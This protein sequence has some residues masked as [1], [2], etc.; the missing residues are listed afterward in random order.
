MV[1]SS[2]EPRVSPARMLCSLSG[3]RCL[4]HEKSMVV[5]STTRRGP[6]GRRNVV[7]PNLRVGLGQGWLPAGT[8]CPCVGA[9]GWLLGRAAGQRGLQEGYLFEPLTALHLSP[10]D[11]APR[12][13]S[14]RARG[15]AGG[16]PPLLRLPQPPTTDLFLL[17][18]GRR[19]DGK[20]RCGCEQ[21]FRDCCLNWA[22]TFR[23]TAG[24]FWLSAS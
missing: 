5:G 7:T 8:S 20:R 14:C 4:G 10:G 11:C 12:D 17:C 2:L 18:R 6:E 23:K 24:S 3:W 16:L 19:R 13:T 15:R 1:P 21:S 22:V 9:R